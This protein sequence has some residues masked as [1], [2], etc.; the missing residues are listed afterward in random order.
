MTEDFFLSQVKR[1]QIHF[2][3]R[4]FNSE[5][6]RVFAREIA[7]VSDEF[8]RNLVDTWIGSRKTT[9]PPLLPDFREAKLTYERNN[10]KREVR[11]ASVGFSN[12]LKD[13]LRDVY[14]VD[15]L[16]EAFELEALKLKLGGLDGKK[17]RGST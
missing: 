11:D 13:V 6:I 9:N 14:K 8:F 17:E 7:I 1:L 12:S 16:K 3:T 2:G 5:S 4:S 15:T 10:L